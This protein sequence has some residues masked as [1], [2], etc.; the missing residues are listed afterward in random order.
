MCDYSLHS[1]ASK[2]GE[3]RRQDC[4]YNLLRHYRSPALLR[5][6][7]RTGCGCSACA[8]GTE[9]AFDQDVSYSQGFRPDTAASLATP[10]SSKP[11]PFP[12]DQHETGQGHASRRAGI[13]E[14]RGRAGH[15]LREDSRR[16]C[17]NCQQNPIA[18]RR[19][20]INADGKSKS[21]ARTTRR[22]RRSTFTSDNSRRI[23]D[24]RAR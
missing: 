10:R 4:H 16:P 2:A 12:A 9:I 3:S 18:P 7:G 20:I 1:V 21:N 23:T 6:R 22:H 24:D 8:P 19:N 5:G 14:R 17:C 15:V 11:R 13:P